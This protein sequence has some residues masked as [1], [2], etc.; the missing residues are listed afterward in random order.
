MQSGDYQQACVK[1]EASRKLDE[2]IGTMLY[3]ADCYEKVGR[4]A[5]AW[6]LFKEAASIAGA[7]NQDSR[8]KLATQR[9][10]ALEPGLVKLTIDVVQKNESLLGFEVRNDGVTVP[11]A[12]YGAPVPVD[13]GE[14]R[15]EASAPGKR[16]FNEVVTVQKDSG[17]I[18]VPL[19]T[20]LTPPA[21]PAQSATPMSEASSSS[22]NTVLSP[23]SGNTSPHDSLPSN[24]STQRVVSYVLGSV[25]LVGI[26]VGSYFGLAAMHRN[27]QSKT[28]CPSDPNVCS[29]GG[30]DI[31]NEALRDARVSTVGF[32]AGGALLAAGTVLFFTAPNGHTAP[33]SPQTA[34]T[35]NSAEFSIAGAW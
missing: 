6:A 32:I 26:G 22:A 2:G 28:D 4:T 12:Q 19:L 18:S 34:L 5:S 1:L 13:P 29:Q 17:H 8:Q 3:L 9:A 31:R 25:G 7:Q 30:V 16:S 14:H 27:T 35:S 11:P 21:G 23:A 20:D 24:G 33:I 15:I 10:R